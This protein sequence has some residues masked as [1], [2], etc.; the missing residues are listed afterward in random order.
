MSPNERVLAEIRQDPGFALGG[1]QDRTFD[2]YVAKVLPG[3]F[4]VTDEEEGITT[5]LGSCVA[6]CIR[7][8]RLGIGGMN[9][10]MLPDNDA[11]DPLAGSARYGTHAMEMLINSLIKL[12]CRRS[13]LEAK[14]FGGGSVIANFSHSQVGERNA[15]FVLEFLRREHIPVSA[16]DLGDVHPRKV[17]Y[18]PKSGKVMVKR[19]AASDNR[20][21]ETESAYRKRIAAKKVVAGAV[22]LF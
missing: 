16:K 11:S 7:D 1:F 6:A 2:S 18:F 10:F 5:T 19:L 20:L 13:H 21:I 15:A 3:E 22:E 8:P 9:H 17:Y 14:V 12:G 4:Y